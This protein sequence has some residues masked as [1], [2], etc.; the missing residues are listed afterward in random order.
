MNENE[1]PV[2]VQVPA[3]CDVGGEE[4]P[5]DQGPAIPD[6]GEAQ[7]PGQDPALREDGH[8]KSRSVRAGLQF[9][10]GRIHRYLREGCAERIGELAPVYL[11]AVMQFVTAQVMEVAGNAARDNLNR[12]TPRHLHT[13]I[14]NDELLS[15]VT[16]MVQGRVVSNSLKTKKC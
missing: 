5:S 14:V 8:V 10:V 2:L 11:A 3:T 7:T 1:D 4:Q 9:P 13:A 15:G 6:G 12:I 16:H